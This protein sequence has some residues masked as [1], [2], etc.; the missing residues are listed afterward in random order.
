MGNALDA[1]KFSASQGLTGVSDPTSSLSA[2]TEGIKTLSDW[3]TKRDEAKEKLKKDTADQYLEAEKKAYE[4]MPTDKT[5]KSNILE[6]LDSYKE[7]LYTNMKLVQR[8]V[9]SANDNL[10]FRENATQGIGV[11]SDMQKDYAKIQEDYLKGARG[12][13]NDKG[14]F[15]PPVYGSGAAALNDIHV[16]L[17]NPDL[18]SLTFNEKG[19]PEVI[20][21]ETEVGPNNIMVAKRDENGDRIPVRDENGNPVPNIKAMAFDGGNNQVMGIINLPKVTAQLTGEGTV[22]DRDYQDIINTKGLMGVITDDIK[23]NKKDGLPDLIKSTAAT[24]IIGVDQQLSVLTDNGPKDKQSQAMNPAMY[25]RLTAKQKAETIEYD[26]FNFETGLMDKGEKTKYIPL[27]MGANNQYVPKFKNIDKKA[28]T[29]LSEY[30]IYNSLEKSIKSGGT[31]FDPNR[32]SR[33]TAKELETKKIGRVEFA[34]RMASGDPRV[35]EEMKAS[36][37]YTDKEDFNEILSKSG[38]IDLEEKDSKGNP[39]KGEIYQVYTSR[40]VEPRTVYHTNEDGSVTSLQDR[41][42]QTLSLIATNPIETQD[43]FNVYTGA[44]NDFNETYNPAK[45]KE[46]TV[47]TGPKTSL[48]METIVEGKGNKA[49]TLNDV[50]TDVIKTADEVD[51]LQGSFGIDEDLLVKGIE[52]ALNQALIKSEQKVDG[53]KVTHDGKNNVTITG[54]NSKGKTITVTGNQSS[55]EPNAMKVE[56]DAILNEFFQNLG[57]DKDYNPGGS[58]SAEVKKDA[59]GNIIK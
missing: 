8:G 6:G 18:Y 55:D 13:T 2:I 3:K 40:G 26:Y 41:T 29:N 27:V 56:I 58:G 39:R 34:K 36:G 46:I 4:N 14:E 19:S 28:S 54:V 32:A 20:M 23:A 1:A 45:F 16:Q 11:V 22:F 9:V 35:L 5:F 7:R 37:L 43:L 25:A 44:G 30:S 12:Y 31:A 59:F 17:N 57:S 47:S 15:V 42:Q 51:N 48:S 24:M 38:L 33:T 52:G 10:I 50:I 49:I 53:L 21:Y